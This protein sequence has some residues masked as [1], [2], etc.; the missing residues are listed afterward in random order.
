VPGQPRLPL[1]Q[2]GR[3]ALPL[4]DSARRLESDLQFQRPAA[5]PPFADLGEGEP[6]P[7]GFALAQL[8]GVYLLAESAEG[9]VLVDIHAAHERIG[10]ERLKRARA[11]GQAIGQPLLVPLS[12]QVSP[13]EAD[14]FEAHRD[15][16]AGLGLAVDRLGPGTLTVREVPAELRDADLE[17]LV[18]DLLSD[19]SVHGRSDRVEEAVNAVLATL[20]CHWSVRANRRLT[21]PEMNALLRDMEGIERADQCNH[22]RPTWIRLSH[23][24]LDRLFSRGR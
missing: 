21:L 10:Y 11:C 16:L 22:G 14:L 19:L 13:R 6:P 8:N 3:L 7:L 2:T 24:E 17:R 9:L 18:R 15:L 1:P 20:A 23:G 12:I 4:A 5:A